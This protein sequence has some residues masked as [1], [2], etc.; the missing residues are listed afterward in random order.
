M[1]RYLEIDALKYVLACAVVGLHCQFLAEYDARLNYMLV[2][3]VFR[4][5]V[6]LFFMMSGYFVTEE[7]IMLMVKR[8]ALLYVVWTAIYAPFWWFGLPYDQRADAPLWQDIV[9]GYYHLWY[10][11]ALILGLLLHKF[12]Q[13]FSKAVQCIMIGITALLGGVLQYAD[14]YHLMDISV[15]AYRNGGCM[16]YP[17]LAIGAR[18]RSRVVQQPSMW[19]IVVSFMLLMIEASINYQQIFVAQSARRPFDILASLYLFCPVVLM[20]VMRYAHRP[21]SGTVGKVALYVYL[22]HPLVII[23]QWQVADMTLTTLTITALVVTT[24]IAIACATLK[25]FILLRFRNNTTR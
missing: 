18:L 9:F 20:V 23:M 7:R 5:A 22:L 6:P 2:N 13:R 25:Q 12:M 11:P 17:F 15:L 19:F 16:A 4:I 3:G 24:L 21:T 10:L 1:Q 8:T 14:N